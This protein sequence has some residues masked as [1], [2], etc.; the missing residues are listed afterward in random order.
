M[1]AYRM[2]DLC[3]LTGMSRQAIHF[4]IQQGLVPEG[5]K[6][7]R[8]MAWY[9]PEHVDRIQ[10]IQRLQ[11]VPGLKDLVAGTLEDGGEGEPVGGSVVDDEDLGPG[12]RS[13]RRQQLGAIIHNN[14]IPGSP[15]RRV[16]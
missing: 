4:Y 10:Q 9:G 7:S 11:A 1:S 15:G 8:N 13:R 6:V 3:E 2:K 12:R 16:T 5:Q 14:P